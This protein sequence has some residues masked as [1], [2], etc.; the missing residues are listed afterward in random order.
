MNAKFNY[1]KEIIDPLLNL[2][3]DNQIWLT[4]PENLPQ[5]AKL[6]Y[7]YNTLWYAGR[8]YYDG[9]PG[10]ICQ[11]NPKYKI[12]MCDPINEKIENFIYDAW[13]MHIEFDETPLSYKNF[14]DKIYGKNDPTDFDIRL[15][16]QNKTMDE[17][18][19]VLMDDKKYKHVYATK[20]KV[21][22]QTLLAIGGGYSYKDGYIIREAS[23]A[24][25]D[26][27]MYGLWQFVNL[28]KLL[29]NKVSELVN[30][31]EVKKVIDYNYD[32]INT[33]IEKKKS[34][35]LKRDMES[36]GMPYDEWKEKNSKYILDISEN[37]YEPYYPISEGYSNI[38]FLDS[39][40]HIS[41]IDA[42]LEICN[43]I[44]DNKHLE[45]LRNVQWVLL[46]IDKFKKLKNEYIKVNL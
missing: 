26:I 8:R 9:E 21:Y 44:L 39:K 18:V 23:G 28:D 2:I 31:K 22:Y 11:D 24:N 46:N 15:A 35:E 38:T 25:Q 30:N 34:D 7:I 42:A 41:Y 10:Y 17:W 40:S 29:F 4:Q 14:T 33:Y 27:D 19:D 5:L 12:E 36:F 20:R 6:G 37:K 45:E 32:V 3:K 43:D 13:G 1:E 16:K